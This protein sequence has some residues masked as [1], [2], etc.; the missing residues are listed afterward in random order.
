M[1]GLVLEGLTVTATVGR[2]T[3]V[4]VHDLALAIEAGESVGLVG[5]SGS[6]KSLTAR[7]ILR[8]LARNLT[9]S[10]SVRFEDREVLGMSERALRE[11]RRHDVAMI[12][13]DPRAAINPVRPIGAFLTEGLRRNEGLAKREA[14]RRAVDVLRSVGFARP[15]EQM[16]RFPHQLSGG[17]L[18]R[19][20]I[21]SALLTPARLLIADEPTTA[22]DVTTQAEVIGLLASLRRSRGLGL[23]FVTHDL[24]LAAALCDRICVMYAGRIVENRA[25]GE[26]AERARH[27]Y[28]RA[29]FDARP[30]VDER[31]ARL[32]AIPGA[33]IAAFEVGERCAFSPRCAHA[34]DACRHAVPALR[35]VGGGEV[36]CV[37][38]DEL[39]LVPGG[40]SA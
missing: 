23:L 3:R 34:T 13:Q 27:P 1:S 39:D 24:D 7:S 36:R 18:Q 26:Y 31:A 29:L 6:G 22:L 14:D 15:E 28:S 37:R 17:M 10:G 19:V 25:A 30:S 20:M 2:E 32:P 21:C 12:F 16:A 8:L 40:G 33:P 5:E 11:Y 4:L 35:P 38:A 9:A